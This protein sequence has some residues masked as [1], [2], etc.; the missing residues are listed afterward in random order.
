MTM[1]QEQ[2][3]KITEQGWPVQLEGFLAFQHFQTKHFA[4]WR[5]ETPMTNLFPNE[6]IVINYTVHFLAV[7]K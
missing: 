5:C 6:L 7:R 1:M 2:E 3:N 4:P